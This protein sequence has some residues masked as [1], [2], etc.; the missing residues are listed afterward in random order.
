M[1]ATGDALIK[2][3]ETISV[4]KVIRFERGRWK[5]TH[6]WYVL[7]RGREV[8]KQ[9]TGIYSNLWG[10]GMREGFLEHLSWYLKGEELAR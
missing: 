2:K 8:T 1:L 4:L 3:R 7:Q 6:V 9:V 10:R 5:L